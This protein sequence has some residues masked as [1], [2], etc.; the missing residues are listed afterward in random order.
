[1]TIEELKTQALEV[2][3]RNGGVLRRLPSGRW[4]GD[5][6][7]MQIPAAIIFELCEE[8]KLK[9][10]ARSRGAEGFATIINTKDVYA[11]YEMS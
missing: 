5:T 3:G 8:G 11:G 4:K 10:V 9:V 7:D 6:K 2:A 1:M